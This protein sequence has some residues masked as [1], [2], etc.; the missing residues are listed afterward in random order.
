[1]NLE[2]RTSHEVNNVLVAAPRYTACTVMIFVYL[3][4]VGISKNSIILISSYDIKHSTGKI[5]LDDV[6]RAEPAGSP[7]SVIPSQQELTSR[8][9]GIE[10]R[11]L[12]SSGQASQEI[13]IRSA[14]ESRP[15]V[16]HAV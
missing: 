13:E 12:A 9:V 14:P 4:Y 6:G 7:F 16:P 3:D 15:L 11:G 2:Q 8:V 5:N 10:R 1:M